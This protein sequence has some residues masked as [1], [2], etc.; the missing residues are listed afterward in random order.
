[1][2]WSFGG[3]R[4]LLKVAIKDLAVLV[5]WQTLAKNRQEKQRGFINKRSRYAKRWI[6]GGESI[7]CGKST[8]NF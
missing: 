5:Y 2:A 3:L 4:A 6:V 1:M 8:I 7:T